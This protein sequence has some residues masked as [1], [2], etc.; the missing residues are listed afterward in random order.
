MLGDFLN[1]DRWLSLVFEG[2]NK[3]YGAYVNREESSDRHLKAMI[4]IT[5]IALGLIFLPRIIKSVIPVTETRSIGQS[6]VVEP[7]IIKTKNITEVQPVVKV[8]LP[9]SIKRSITFTPPVI[10]DDAKVRNDD[11]VKAQI[12]LTETNAAISNVT[13]EGTEGGVN[14]VTAEEITG[15]GDLEGTVVS[16]PLLTAEQMPRFPGGDAALMKWLKDNINYPVPAMELNIQG[17]VVLRFVVNQDGSI[18]NVEILKGFDP[19]CDKEAMR[20]VKKMPSWIPGKQNG[21]PVAVYYSL[22]V[23]FRLQNY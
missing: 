5:V 8:A 3:E 11:L 10:T 4:I 20:V 6:V 12:E 7:T 17:R 19:S 9:L 16:K 14:V 21:N 15:A 2:R 22:P 13:V 23:V 18:G 1:S